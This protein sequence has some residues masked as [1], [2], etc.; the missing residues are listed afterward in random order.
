MSAQKLPNYVD[1]FRRLQEIKRNKG[2]VPPI[3]FNLRLDS[4]HTDHQRCL[5]CTKDV[6]SQSMYRDST[7]YSSS[8][9]S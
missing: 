7:T 1:I 9:L 3:D 6:F 5:H 8:R 2:K 4:Y